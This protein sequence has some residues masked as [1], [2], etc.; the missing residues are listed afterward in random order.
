MIEINCQQVNL[1]AVGEIFLFYLQL[2]KM[3]KLAI[4][5]FL[6]VFYSKIMPKNIHGYFS[7]RL[8]IKN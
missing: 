2:A 6:I 7:T 1:I 5:A 8:V 3:R 4:F